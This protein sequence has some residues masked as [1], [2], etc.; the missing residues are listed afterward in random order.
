MAQRIDA[1]P[2]KEEMTDHAPEGTGAGDPVIPLAQRITSALPRMTGKQRTLAH[3][4]ADNQHFV[5][6]ASASEVGNRTGCS[7]ATVV[8]FS[9]SLGYQGYIDLQLAVREWMFPRRTAVQRLED[10]LK[11]PLSGDDVPALVF[12]TDMQNVERTQ[13][14]TRNG[15]VQAAVDDLL[16]ARQTVV[17]GDGLAAG[18]AHLFAH[19]L[20]VIGLPVQC[21]TSG[22]EPLAVVLAFLQP[23]DVLVAIGFWRNLWDVVHAV[24]QAQ[25]V[26]C[27]TIC[28]TDNRLSPLARLGDHSFLVVTE[29]VAHSLSPVAAVSLM[30]A[31]VA[32]ISM[33]MP[34]KVVESLRRL[35]EAYRR[36]QLLTE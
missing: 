18:L 20:R 9:Q 15:R 27:K 21:V 36:G 12:A 17:M 13:A 22:G 32:A 4:I 28:I 16:R 6:F 11:N 8:R 5:A 30:N 10:R 26:G 35:D 7:A 1:V 2:V 3:F 33:R 23:E 24:R 19:S 34:E 14:L 31:M 29:G 25:Q